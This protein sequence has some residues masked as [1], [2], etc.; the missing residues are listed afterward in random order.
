MLGHSLDALM[1]LIWQTTLILVAFGL[2]IM[3]GLV[4]R[5]LLEEWRHARHRPARERLRQALLGSLNRPATADG[6]PT[7][8]A[9]LAGGLPRAEIARLVDE[10]AQMVRGEARRR[11]AAF[12]VDA[13]VER[14]WLGRL[15][16]RFAPLRL[17][18]ARCLALFDTPAV[19]AALEARLAGREPA[20]R[21]AAAE[22]LAQDPACAAQLM[23]RLANDP[24][25]LGRQAGR[26]WHRLA[27]SAPETLVARLTAAARDDD[28]TDPR[29]LA[30]LVEALGEVGHAAAA[31]PIEALLGGHGPALDRA[32]LT[33]LD[34]LKHPAVVRAARALAVS[35]D[36]ASRRAAMAVLA[37]RARA[38]DLELLTG[39]T[40]DPLPDIA[41]AAHALVTRLTAAAADGASP[42]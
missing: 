25:W 32:A 33:A 9:A 11:L 17:D 29:L 7:A 10:L 19:R 16:S 24:V 36:D 22:A 35:T 12:A 18:A 8:G 15:A 42:A 2:L 41:A 14:L 6:V 37:L 21:L 26:F 5:R 27:A 13:G 38:R 23:A 20:L 1:R 4:V 34:R 30:R 31:A 3:A 39:M 28:D 40:R